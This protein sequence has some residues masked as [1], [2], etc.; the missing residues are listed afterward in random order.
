MSDPDKGLWSDRRR[1]VA[2]DLGEKQDAHHTQPPSLG[3]AF[4]T[5]QACL[6]TGSG[7]FAPIPHRPL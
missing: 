1:A 3:G 4:W 7:L 5:S 6:A 2:S